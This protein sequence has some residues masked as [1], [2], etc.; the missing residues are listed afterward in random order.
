MLSHHRERLTKEEGLAQSEFGYNSVGLGTTRP[1]LSMQSST[2]GG[3]Y[4]FK[5]YEA[6]RHSIEFRD[7]LCSVVMQSHGRLSTIRMTQ[8]DSHSETASDA[9]KQQLLPSHSITPRSAHSSEV[10][11]YSCPFHSRTLQYIRGKIA[12]PATK[13]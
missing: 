4:V 1:I 2:R 11:L 10:V 7:I 12:N 5:V 8:F 13:C 6:E 3:Y 9:P